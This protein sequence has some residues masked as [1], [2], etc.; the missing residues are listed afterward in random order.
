MAR[1]ADALMGGQLLPAAWVDT[2]F[3]GRTPEAGPGALAAY[4][5]DAREQPNGVRV[6]SKGGYVDGALAQV[7]L[8]PDD[9]W[10]VVVLTNTD[11]WGGEAVA[12][13][14][15]KLVTQR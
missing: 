7:E 1:F 11:L 12:A 2:M 6:L 13:K 14:A 3:A 9:R 15:R 10:A 4:G 5:F 8:Y